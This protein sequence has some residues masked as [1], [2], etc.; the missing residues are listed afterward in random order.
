MASQKLANYLR[1]HRKR[2]YLSQDEVAFLLG[3]KDGSKISRYENFSRQPTPETIFAYEI[4]FRT[5]ARQLFAG[6]Y[7]KVEKDVMRRAQLLA[8][9]ITTAKPGPITE[10]KLSA[11]RAISGSESGSSKTL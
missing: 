4:I 6:T 7:L 3:C 11:L 2:S 9:K 5:L 8:R 10:R 1:M